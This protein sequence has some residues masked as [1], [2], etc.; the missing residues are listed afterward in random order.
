MTE[1]YVELLSNH[2]TRL[3]FLCTWHKAYRNL[4]KMKNWLL[5]L[6]SS[7]AF[8]VVFCIFLIELALYQLDES[9]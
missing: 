6:L 4:S 9:K 1:G 2:W 5:L 3:Q 8:E 7:V